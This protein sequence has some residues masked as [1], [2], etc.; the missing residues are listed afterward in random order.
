MYGPPLLVLRINQG[1]KSVDFSCDAFRVIDKLIQV[2]VRRSV[3]FEMF[4]RGAEFDSRKAK[5]PHRSLQTSLAGLQTSDGRQ[6][7]F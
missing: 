2:R 5:L 7:L 3:S 4:N 6:A 1:F